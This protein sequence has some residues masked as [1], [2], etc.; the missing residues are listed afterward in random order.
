M[1]NSV[2]RPQRRASRRTP[3]GPFAEGRAKGARC[4]P[5]RRTSDMAES[6][7]E[8]RGVR[9]TARDGGGA[10]VVRT[11]SEVQPSSPGDSPPDKV[12]HPSEVVVNSSAIQLCI[13]LT[14][15]AAGSTDR[16]RALIAA[17]GAFA[18]RTPAAHAH[19]RAAGA[20]GPSKPTLSPNPCFLRRRLRPPL[21]SI[22]RPG[23]KASWRGPCATA[24]G[25]GLGR[26]PSD[27][28]CVRPRNERWAFVARQRPRN[29]RRLHA[30]RLQRAARLL[31]AAKTDRVSTRSTL[32]HAALHPPL[33]A[34]R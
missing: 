21:R 12:R 4:R 16:R 25:W 26:M 30:P 9:A 11:R 18:A 10:A 6:E 28:R 24:S 1:P 8:D 14:R 15:L 33:A 3:H 17:R 34:Q 2:P 20:R 13:T 27:G 31:S 5:T 19:G 22:A 32:P 7:E 29:S 23:M